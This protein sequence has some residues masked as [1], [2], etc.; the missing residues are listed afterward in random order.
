MISALKLYGQMGT[1]SYI[2][3]LA[4]HIELI[5]LWRP[6]AN[7]FISLL[8]RHGFDESELG[9]EDVQAYGPMGGGYGAYL[10]K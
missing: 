3:S 10:I 1:T 5:Q 2:R 4:R 8:K 6:D 7:G 9:Q